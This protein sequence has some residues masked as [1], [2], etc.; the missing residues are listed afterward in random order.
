MPRCP[1]C[2]YSLV[3]L[4]H[5]RKYKCAKC[6]KLFPKKE[7][8]VK[9]FQN[10]NKKLRKED[11]EN[12]GQELKREK[13]KLSKEERLARSK[14]AQRKYREQN[15]TEYNK[16]KR[17]YWAKNK[18]HLLEKRRQ[19]YKKKKAKILAQ[20]KFWGENHKIERRLNNLRWEQ[21]LLAVRMF[22]FNVERA[23]N[24]QIQ[25]VLLT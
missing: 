21:K 17:D 10:W 5:R 4:E 18:K 15:R 1:N 3:L 22:E 24:L 9:E 11:E 14:K 23:C 2:N 8:D 19:N 20:Q 6:G 16:K 13:P 7:I 25:N 12:I